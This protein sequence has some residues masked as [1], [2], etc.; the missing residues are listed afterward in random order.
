VSGGASIGFKGRQTDD[1]SD[2]LADADGM[3]VPMRYPC[4]L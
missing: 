3:V 1:A 2:E 4:A